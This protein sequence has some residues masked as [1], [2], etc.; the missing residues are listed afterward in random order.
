MVGF[1]TGY[2]IHFSCIQYS[3]QVAFRDE[4]GRCR[5]GSKNDDLDV[6]FMLV[7]VNEV[8]DFCEV[9]VSLCDWVLLVI[10]SLGST[11]SMTPY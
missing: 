4:N 2:I 10:K 6:L 1:R 11:Y 5:C 3:S 7:P 9:I 8:T